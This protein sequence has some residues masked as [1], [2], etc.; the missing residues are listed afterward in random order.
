MCCWAESDKRLKSCTTCYVV[1]TLPGF[2]LK[3]Y[4]KVTLFTN[5]MLVRWLESGHP[6]HPHIYSMSWWMP[7][8]TETMMLIP[9]DGYCSVWW[10]SSTSYIAA[11]TSRITVFGFKTTTLEKALLTTLLISQGHPGKEGPPGEKGALVGVFMKYFNHSGEIGVFMHVWCSGRLP[12]CLQT[13][14]SV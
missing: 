6:S 9:I 7:D 3:S 1:L 11:S 14:W 13:K 10:D 4:M 2:V 12:T 8:P 5:D